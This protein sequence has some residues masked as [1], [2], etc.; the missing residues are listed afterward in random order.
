MSAAP[1]AWSSVSD[2]CCPGLGYD[3]HK[4]S[5]HRE[6]SRLNV[7]VAIMSHEK[8]ADAAVALSAR[9]QGAPIVWDPEPGAPRSALRTAVRA[10]SAWDPSATHHLVVQDD[11]TVCDAFLDRVRFAV[12]AMPDAALSFYSNWESANGAAVRLALSAGSTWIESTHWEYFPTLATVVPTQHLADY[13]SFASSHLFLTGDDD[14][15]LLDFLQSRNVAG[16]L[17]APSAVEH[18]ALETLVG[19]ETRRAA[20]YVSDQSEFVERISLLHSYKLCPFLYRG[21]AYC[22]MRLESGDEYGY[23]HVHWTKAIGML[24]LD[25]KELLG[26]F[27][28]DLQGAMPAAQR[29]LRAYTFSAWMTAFL[30]GYIPRSR[31]ISV[32]GGRLPQSGPAYDARMQ[33]TLRTAFEGGVRDSALP[34]DVFRQAADEVLGVMMRGLRLGREHG[35]RS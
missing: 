12:T 1:T 33:Q 21:V 17:A 28:T 10:W 18:G 25:E 30:L 11:V 22:L 14:E 4:S 5:S 27:E 8:R 19:N 7:S 26:A 9:L 34:A 13:E 16:Y 32:D 3:Q 24:G 31:H 23:K 2:A 20:S 29:S 35:E 15:I 6:G